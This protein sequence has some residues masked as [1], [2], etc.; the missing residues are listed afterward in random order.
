MEAANDRLKFRA[1]A[2]EPVPPTPGSP[3]SET[4]GAA[5]EDSSASDESNLT[6]HRTG[7]LREETLLKRRRAQRLSMIAATAVVSHVDEIEGWLL[8]RS[9]R[10]KWQPRY[11]K[12]Q[13]H[14]LI[15]SAKKGGNV[16][17]GVD[18]ACAES[19]VTQF[20]WS[21]GTFQHDCL[22]I[23]GF[24]GDDAE[25]RALRTLELRFD[26][27][28][29]HHDTKTDYTDSVAPTIWEWNRRL[30][31]GRTMAGGLV[32]KAP[33]FAAAGDANE[34]E[35]EDDGA[36]PRATLRAV[37]SVKRRRARRLSAISLTAPTSGTTGAT[38]GSVW[39]H[40]HEVEGY[41]LK[42][43]KLGRW[44]RRYFTTQ[45]HYLL[46]SK[47][48]GGDM[49]GGVDL[50]GEGSTVVDFTARVSVLSVLSVPYVP[51]RFVRILLTI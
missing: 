10:G 11:F 5:F 41:L 40:E 9:A 24:D 20:Q 26:I 21:D 44:Q 19:S 7:A 23:V 42:K 35:S 3:A 36:V 48:K 31:T 22:R 27:S 38:L 12:T 28:N 15:Y 16:L 30:E 34:S 39:S 37:L 49:L 2:G 46:Y 29:I 33:G 45:S 6:P 47:K 1:E 17:G 25:D 32:P 51:L 43:S 50:A 4:K 14:Y 8:K 18:L 13:S